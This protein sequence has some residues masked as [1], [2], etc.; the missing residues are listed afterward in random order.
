MVQGSNWKPSVREPRHCDGLA[1][2]PED[3]RPC[4][5]IAADNE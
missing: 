5:Y 1:G 3:K 4:W 2:S